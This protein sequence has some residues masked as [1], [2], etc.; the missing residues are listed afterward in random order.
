MVVVSFGAGAAAAAAVV[1]VGPG[2]Q[3]Q[4]GPC[5]GPGSG[6]VLAPEPDPA[7]ASAPIPSGRS[8]SEDAVEAALLAFL[9]LE[10]AAV[11]GQILGFVLAA[12][13]AAGSVVSAD[14]DF[15]LAEQKA[16][17]PGAVA[18]VVGQLACL[19]PGSAP[20]RWGASCRRSDLL[21]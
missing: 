20:D 21:Y 1:A 10:L 2:D 4:S 12:A 14:L 11:G 19:V 17:D 8:S 13:A 5:H 16:S 15:G 3:A 18:V 6:P 7:P 9:D